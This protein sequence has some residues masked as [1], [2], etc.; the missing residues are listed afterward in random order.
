MIICVPG[1]SGFAIHHNTSCACALFSWCRH[2]K[3]YQ[4]ISPSATT[5]TTFISIRSLFTIPVCREM[6]A[7]KSQPR[8]LCPIYCFSTTLHNCSHI[9]RPMLQSLPHG[10]NFRKLFRRCRE[11]S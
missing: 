1:N 3:F 4:S 11:I 8:R 2:H 9:H 6:V 7:K 5:R 10:P